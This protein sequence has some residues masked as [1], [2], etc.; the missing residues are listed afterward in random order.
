[1]CKK[2]F[3]SLSV[4]F[5]LVFGFGPLNVANAVPGQSGERYELPA[6]EVNLV[7]P[8]YAVNS[9]GQAR[10][11]SDLKVKEFTAD[12]YGIRNTLRP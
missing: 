7:A 5:A 9:I 12:T 1:M 10:R 2:S 8:D 6:G 11:D 3:F 4:A